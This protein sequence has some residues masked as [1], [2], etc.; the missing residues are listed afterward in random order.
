[1]KPDISNAQPRLEGLAGLRPKLAMGSDF[2][3]PVSSSSRRTRTSNVAVARPLVP[4]KF[5]T[6]GSQ[7]DGR[8]AH[9]WVPTSTFRVEL[10]RSALASLAVGAPLGRRAA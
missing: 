1:M 3:G 4:M 5:A 8:E 6:V 2:L 10:G 7:S 9:Q